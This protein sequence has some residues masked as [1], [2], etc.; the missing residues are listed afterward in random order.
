MI[1]ILLVGRDKSSLAAL[2]SGLV[3]S[4]VQLTRADSGRKGISMITEND[5]DLVIADENIGDMTGIDFIREVVAKKPMVNS[6]VISSM[7]SE[8]FHETSEGLGIL[9]QLPVRPNEAD[10]SRLFEHLNKI[11]N[12]MKI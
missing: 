7:S 12:A 3:K 6:A 5:F 1:N 10:A 11:F 2:S 9:M 8:D 4:D